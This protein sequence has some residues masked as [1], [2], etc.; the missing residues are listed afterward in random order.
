MASLVGS[1]KNSEVKFVRSIEPINLEIIG[2]FDVNHLNKDRKYDIRLKR[3]ER[4]VTLKDLSLD[5]LIQYVKT[6]R[7]LDLDVYVAYSTTEE[8]GRPPRGRV[9]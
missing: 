4:E 9:R 1:L 7:E 2:D 5:L 8:K 3:T 6:A